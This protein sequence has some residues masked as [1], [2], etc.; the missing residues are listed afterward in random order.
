MRLD[1]TILEELPYAAHA[2]VMTNLGTHEASMLT[3]GE[4]AKLSDTAPSAIRFYE[5]QG[6]IASQRTSGNQRRYQPW[7]PCVVRVARVAQRVGL[8]VREITRALDD[9][10][11]H[12]TPEDWQRLTLH[13]IS[14][15][16]RRIAQL[17]A[18]RADLAFGAKLCEVPRSVR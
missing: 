14:E 6:L 11:E 16:E 1:D 9:V 12:P 4:V 13:L 5:R 7:V 8:S 10:P 18:A 15:A 17:E 2:E 3:V